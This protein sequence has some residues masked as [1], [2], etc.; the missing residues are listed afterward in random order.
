M[1]DQADTIDQEKTDESH[2]QGTV[3]A[4]ALDVP[5]WDTF[6]YISPE[7]LNQADTLGRRVIV[8]FG[9]RRV[10]GYALKIKERT[11]GFE[12]KEIE[13]VLDE[14]PLFTPSMVRLFEWVS[15]Y[16]LCPIGQVLASLLPS[17]LG[18]S[19]RRSASLTEKALALLEQGRAKGAAA[20]IL[21][22]MKD[23]PCKRPPW[24]HAKILS[25]A[26]R[27]LIR[28]EIPKKRRR[29]MGPL[30]KPFVKIADSRGLSTL[31]EG[32]ERELLTR[33]EKDGPVAVSELRR[34]FP[35]TDYLIA[36]WARKGVLERYRLPVERRHSYCIVR[37]YPRPLELF[38]QQ[39]RA[40]VQ[41]EALL[42]RGAFACCLLHGVTGSGKTEIY[43][44]AAE[45]AIKRG[46]QVLVLVPEI[47]LATY[48]EGVF[49]ARLG[50]RTAVYH[51]G[52]GEGER[53]D[54]WIRIAKG[55]VDLV[56]GARSALF[57]PLERLGLIIVDEEHDPAYKQDTA[58]RYQGR[59][60]AVMRGKL[61]DAV[62][63]LGSGTPSVQSYHNAVSGK[64]RMLSM[65][66]RIE[67]RPLPEI[68]LVDMKEVEEKDGEMP[69]LSPRLFNA[70]VENLSA[71]DQSLLFLNRRGYHR[72]YLCRMCGGILKCLNCDV[73]LTYHKKEGLLLCHYCGFS[74][75]GAGNLRCASCGTQAFKA[76]GFGTERLEAELASRL[77]SA[78]IARMDADSTRRKGEAFGLLKRFAD[79]EID[80]LVGTQII[81]K[82]Y[83]F[84]A[85]TLVGVVAADLSL[86][87]PD[88]RA[89]ERTFQ[90]LSQV[91]GRAG[92]GEK[93]GRVII[94][95][96]N[97]S[98]YALTAAK[99]HD[100]KAFAARETELRS[101]AG[102]PPFRNLAVIKMQG[103]RK[104]DTR[105]AASQM[106]AALKD[107]P[108]VHKDEIRVMGPVEAP[109]AKIK[110]RYRFQIL[111]KARRHLILQRI[112]RE[113]MLSFKARLERRGVECTAD[114]DPYQML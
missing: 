55:E 94:Q 59:D 44:R 74:S 29:P 106:A 107:L 40:L 85:V 97:P 39:E 61:Q 15:E 26:K 72:L 35:K 83:D 86:G 113:T 28:L 101:S 75:S 80:I 13:D 20:Q 92:R 96:F 9:A 99:G 10:T 51:S 112:L 36:K 11:E 21:T 64:Y 54:Q 87:F 22:W 56:I 23:N 25:L 68:E 52:L 34:L 30:F 58:P 16:Y 77:P 12:L 57:A 18:V 43:F 46:R 49:L 109:I 79:K 32:P 63:V 81:A 2:R 14:H 1:S 19:L 82:G 6:D 111:L 84:P 69:M 110:G 76:Y 70:L 3:V 62:V 24:P 33:I 47:S 73:A 65:P 90:L 41:I 27:G 95:T 66:E 98:H 89:S 31:T 104:E 114:I 38:P 48:M 108:L 17:S 60:A 42:G 67:S 78:R 105:E 8:P 37:P 45:A 91:A 4:V 102:Y 5:L 93:P 53:Y 103:G 50:D 71:G 100:Y 88:F 7:G